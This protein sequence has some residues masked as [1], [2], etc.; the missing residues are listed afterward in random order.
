MNRIICGDVLTV[1][2]KLERAKMIF[3]DPPDNIGLKYDNG[4]S[5]NIDLSEYKIQMMRWLQIALDSSDVV[6]W[7]INRLHQNWFIFR[8]NEL[9]LHWVGDADQIRQFI[10]YFTFGQHR[11]KDCGNNYRPIFRVAPKDYPW[12]T[13]AIRVP[14]ARQTKYNDKRANAKGRVPGDV[15]EFSRVCGTFKERRTWHPTQHPQ[16]LV[17]RAILMSTQPGDLVIDPFAGTGTTLRACEATGRRCILIEVS[18]KYCEEIS[19]ETGLP[20]EK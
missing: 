2:P 4:R 8:L 5:D 12:N 3:A 14:S 10:W 17:E 11:D 15:W 20:V 19:R 1:L 9:L 16:A 6:W 18:E 13:D 7:S